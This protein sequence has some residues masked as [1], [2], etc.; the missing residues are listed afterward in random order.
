MLYSFSLLQNH[1]S[2]RDCVVQRS[3]GDGGALRHSRGGDGV[4]SHSRLRTLY[5]F[6]RLCECGGDVHH[7]S[8]HVS[9]L[10]HSSGDGDDLVHMRV[11]HCECSCLP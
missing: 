11:V 9:A 5:R 1:R 3:S 7:S 4:V 2:E 6:L 10:L 8:A